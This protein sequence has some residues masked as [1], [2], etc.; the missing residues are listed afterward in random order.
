MKVQAQQKTGEGERN[1]G[2]VRWRRLMM[3][4]NKRTAAASEI[5]RQEDESGSEEEEFDIDKKKST[6]YKHLLSS[7]ECRKVFDD[8]WFSVICYAR[9]FR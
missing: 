6:I 9:F 7:P 1:D 8:Y 2:T 3:G 5:W 4:T